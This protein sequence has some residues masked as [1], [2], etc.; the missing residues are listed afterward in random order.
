LKKSVLLFGPIGDFGGRDV[1]VNIISKS[2][3][4]EFDVKI[5]S[6]IYI[7]A[8]S[9]AVLDLKRP[10]FTSFQI[11]LNKRFFF[12][13][14]TSYLFWLKNFTKKKKTYAFTK[15]KISKLFF[16][17]NKHKLE[18]LKNEVNEADVIIVC[19]QLSSKFLKE[20]IHFSKLLNKPCFVRTT[21]TIKVFE[22][23]NFDFLK[24]VTKFIHHSESNASNLNTILN[25]PYVV[26]DQCALDDLKLLE[27]PISFQKVLRFGFLGRL[28]KEKGILELIDYFS[29]QNNYKLTVAGKGNLMKIIIGKKNIEYLGQI[30]PK[31]LADFFDKIDVLIISSYEESGPLVGLEAMAAGKIIISTEVGAMKDRLFQTQNDFWFKIDNVNEL[32]SI[33]GHLNTLDLN[34][35]AK[36]NREKYIREYKFE[37]IQQKYLHLIKNFC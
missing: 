21:G 16:N 23:N 31:L 2:L 36:E 37:A 20:I 22:K 32:N 19:S 5:F 34:S 9:Y 10:N 28:S 15:N 24:N 7:T 8:Q 6:S 27:L 11:E 14:I 26:I 18:I 13:K 30:E 29:K 17:F 12:L 35:I 33:F 3:V 4:N 1:E 25:L